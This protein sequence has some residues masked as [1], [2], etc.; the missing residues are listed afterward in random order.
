[1][2]TTRY[3]KIAG[4]QHNQAQTKKQRKENTN[5]NTGRLTKR[6]RFL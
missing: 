3:N 4:A 5:A 1:M 2:A 6:Q